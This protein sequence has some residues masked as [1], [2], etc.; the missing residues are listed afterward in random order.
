MSCVVGKATEGLENELWRRW[1]DGKL[2]NSQ[3]KG[4]TSNKKFVSKIRKQTHLLFSIKLSKAFVCVTCG[5]YVTV[6]KLKYWGTYI[7]FADKSK[8]QNYKS[9]V[10]NK[11]AVI[12][13][14][15]SVPVHRHMLQYSW[16]SAIYV[17]PVA[18]KSRTSK[19]L[20]RWNFHFS[21]MEND[22]EYRS[23]VAIAVS[24]NFIG[25]RPLL[26]VSNTGPVRYFFP[27]HWTFVTLTIN[28]LYA[29]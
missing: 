6:W 28:C 9:S 23:D 14:Q 11:N 29:N 3:E 26:L 4:F 12:H 21:S 25:N 8:T 20:F 22:Y 1:S 7:T 10:Y 13:N 24:C 17:N 19:M 27:W 18:Y 16:Q 15:L 2:V 5:L